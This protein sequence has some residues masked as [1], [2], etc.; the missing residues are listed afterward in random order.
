VLDGIA[1][2]ELSISQRAGGGL[3]VAWRTQELYY[4]ADEDSDSDGDCDSDQR[5]TLMVMQEPERGSFEIAAAGGLSTAA[6]AAAGEAAAVS[7]LLCSSVTKVDHHG[8]GGHYSDD[9]DSDSYESD[10]DD[11]DDSDSDESSQRSDESYDEYEARLERD[12]DRR[13]EGRQERQQERRE[14]RQ[15]CNAEP[16]RARRDGVA[17]TIELPDFVSSCL[18]TTVRDARRR[19]EATVG[20]TELAT[21]LSAGAQHRSIMPGCPPIDSAKFRSLWQPLYAD[22]HGASADEALRPWQIG[23]STVSAPVLMMTFPLNGLA[24]EVREQVDEEGEPIAAVAGLAPSFRNFRMLLPLLKVSDSSAPPPRQ[25]QMAAQAFA[26]ARPYHFSP[27]LLEAALGASSFLAALAELPAFQR[28]VLEAPWVELLWRVSE[29]ALA[30]ADDALEAAAPAAVL[31]VRW[32]TQAM[33]L[34]KYSISETANA[35]EAPSSVGRLLRVAAA[36]SPEAAMFARSASMPHAQKSESAVVA[37][38]M[39][40]PRLQPKPKQ[41]KKRKPL[42]VGSQ[43]MLHK[44]ACNHNDAEGRPRFGLGA[45]TFESVGT[46]TEIDFSNDSYVKVVIEWPEQQVRRGDRLLV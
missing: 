8:G 23:A 28:C 15:E 21:A 42:E 30:Q 39:P 19:V 37:E 43:V 34:L 9:E 11:D 7:A 13:A 27:M 29:G 12:A 26:L 3:S 10:S 24:D 32:R 14:E 40:A 38:A 20:L 18:L 45:A 5:K 16:A 44:P 22:Q 2:V 36:A 6:A 46:V 1:E 17:A 35:A 4:G 33:A 41:K 25:E 31:A